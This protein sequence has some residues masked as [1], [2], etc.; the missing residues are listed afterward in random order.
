MSE[1]G[2]GVVIVGGGHA[3]GTAAGMLRQF[4]YEGAIAI[5]GE[6][7]IAPYQR[8]PLSKAWLKGETDAEGLALRADNFYADEN[9]DLRLSSRAVSIDRGAKTVTLEGGEA[10]PY[11]TLIIATG[12]HARRLSLPGSELEG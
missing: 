12:A 2:P 7:P 10:L 5:V 3:G 8:P 1:P 4:G 11:E 6:E 9:I